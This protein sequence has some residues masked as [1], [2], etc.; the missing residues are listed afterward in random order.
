MYHRTYVKVD[1]DKILRN[2]IRIRERLGGR[3]KLLSVV[4]AD[5]YGH[6]VQEVSR[7]LDKH[8]DFFGVAGVSEALELIDC[9][10]SKPVLVLGYASPEEYSDVVKNDIRIPIFSYNDARALSEVASAFGKTAKFHFC[11]DTG[12]SRI[13]FQANEKIT[14]ICREI[15]RLPGIFAEGIFSHYATAD[16]SDLT[17]AVKQKELFCRFIQMLNAGGVDVP[18]KHI[19]NSAGIMVFDDSFDMVRAGIITYGL[20]PSEQVDKSLLALEPA[21]EWKSSVSYIKTLGPGREVSYGATYKTTADTVVATIPVGYADG[22]PRCLGNKGRVIINGAYAPIIGR[23]CM[24][25]FMVDVTGIKG[26]GVGSPVT[27]IGSQ[28]DLRLTMEEVSQAAD[29]FNY[30]LP[31][32]ISRRVPRI[33]YKNGEIYKITTYKAE[34]S[35]Y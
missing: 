32:R 13:G 20:Y 8:C 28:G 18:V 17:R 21:M 1:L 31:C 10:I 9:G 6:G 24:D 27:L 14:D 23:I 35:A 11:V 30:E 15:T 29:S 26:V 33:Y 22:Y 16:E 25:Q 3:T 5:A 34:S 19:S 2:T 12:M 7:V 4:K